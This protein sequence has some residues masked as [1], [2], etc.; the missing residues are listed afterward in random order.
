VEEGFDGGGGRRRRGQAI[1]FRARW[2]FD[3][4]HWA[5]ETSPTAIT[6]TNLIVASLAGALKYFTRMQLSN[7]SNKV[8]H[9][10]LL[11]L[12][13]NYLVAKLTAR[14]DVSR[15]RSLRAKKKLIQKRHRLFRMKQ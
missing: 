15:M 10:Q 1:F 7:R 11:K 6:Q 12:N 3:E 4:M 2:L 8:D 5:C 9:D 13:P 14:I